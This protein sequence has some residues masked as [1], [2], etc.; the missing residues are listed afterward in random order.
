ML[1][2]ACPCALGLATPA[3]MVVGT[4]KGAANGILVK[5]GETLEEANKVDVV[6]FDKTGTITVGEPSVTDV[7]SVGALA[8]EE[9]LGL[10]ASAEMGSEHPV[11]QAM[12]RGARAMKLR[13]ERPTDFEASPGTGVEATVGK[14]RILVGNRGLLARKKVSL[15]Q[16][17]RILS[18]LED[19]GKTTMAVAVDGRVE[20][21][22]AV[23][24]TVKPSAKPAV[25]SLRNEGVRVV[26]ITGDNSRTAKAVASQVG[27]DEVI[28]EVLPAQKSEAVDRLRKEGN[29]VAM[30]G[31]GINDAPA[32]ARADVGIAIGSGTDVAIE[33]AGIVLLRSNLEDVPA[34]LKL[35][36]ATI[37]KVR[38]NLF[39]AFA[40]NII[41]I[42][43]AA[44]G[45]L[46]P[47][48]AGVAMALSSVTVVT[49]SLSLN[50]L[51]LT[52]VAPV[53]PAAPAVAK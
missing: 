28:A 53:T 4:G 22:V 17:D 50:R 7:V 44:S 47:I 49:N 18:E 35:S 19:Q 26:M 1:I 8:E 2:I 12:I 5:G 24:D 43:V 15:D 21:V 3:A 42:P 20:G 29:R 10:A 14:N 23:A 30:V 37:S 46:N 31:D 27:I 9:I 16:A 11:G 48:L 38:Q 45:F 41:L 32:L 25:T 40:Y 13:V 6:I 52:N 39:W 33:T 34:A 36:R 51:K